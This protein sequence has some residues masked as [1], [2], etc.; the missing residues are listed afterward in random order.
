VVVESVGHL[1]GCVVVFLY[2]GLAPGRAEDG[3]TTVF[4]KT[5]LYSAVLADV[6]TAQGALGVVPGVGTVQ[7]HIDGT[8]FFCYE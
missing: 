2:L 1:S 4:V 3:V 5:N 7:R 8:G 6:V